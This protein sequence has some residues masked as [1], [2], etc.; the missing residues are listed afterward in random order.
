MND[1]VKIK[2]TLSIGFPTATRVETIEIGGE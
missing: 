2:L 1:K